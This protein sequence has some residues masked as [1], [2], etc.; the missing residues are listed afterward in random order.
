MSK[1]SEWYKTQDVEFREEITNGEITELF[2]D[3]NVRAISLQELRILDQKYASGAQ[4][5]GVIEHE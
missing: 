2:I 3:R 5:N 4:N 1:W